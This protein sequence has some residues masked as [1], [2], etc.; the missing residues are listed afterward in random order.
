MVLEPVAGR[1]V[2]FDDFGQQQR[3]TGGHGLSRAR[4][5]EP[6]QDQAFM[7]GV[8]VDENQAVCRLCNDI[9]FRNLSAGHP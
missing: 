2:E 6:F 3:L 5:L 7:R 1:L 9:G 8:L 4:G